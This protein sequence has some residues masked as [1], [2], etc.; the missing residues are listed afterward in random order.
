MSPRQADTAPHPLVRV[1]VGE[2]DWGSRMKAAKSLPRD[3][4]MADLGTLMEFINEPRE[5]LRTSA[6]HALVDAVI[7]A[8]RRQ[9]TFPNGMS[10][11]L[12][13]LYR[14]SPDPVLQSYALQYLWCLYID[15]DDHHRHEPDPAARE[16]ILTTL[17]KAASETDRS[18]SGTALMAL[19]AITRSAA[20][21]QEPGT[22]KQLAAHAGDI[23]ASF[24]KAASSP[25]TDK[26]CRISVLQVCAMRGLT[27]ILPVARNLAADT[28]ED[29]NI[30]I[31]AIAAIGMLGSAGE[32]AYLL[33]SLQK[34]GN[35]L[36]YAAEPALEKLTQKSP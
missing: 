14:G 33:E 36:A 1:I 5:D 18:C 22:R 17:I 26:L 19:N 13:R 31:S 27:G 2:S 23:D 12:V 32:D 34:Q 20:L 11:A 15:R 10:E 30:R 21:Q 24:L 9:E 8:M 28:K 6:G 25:E 29:P 3:L 35:R 7:N 4:A 16:M